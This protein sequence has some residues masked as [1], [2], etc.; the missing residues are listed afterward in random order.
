MVPP[1]ASQKAAYEFWRVGYF[2]LHFFAAGQRAGFKFINPIGGVDAEDIFVCCRF[3][4]EKVRLGGDMVGQE[5][6]C[7]QAEFLR[8]EDVRAEVQVVALVIDEF[9]WQHRQA[10]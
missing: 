4:P 5:F 3:G 9:E 7:D 6:F 10:V 2:E 1:A 8:G